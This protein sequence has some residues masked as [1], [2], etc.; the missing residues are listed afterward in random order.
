MEGEGEKRLTT[1]CEDLDFVVWR[2]KKVFFCFFS[3]V[4][5]II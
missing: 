2:K 5:F 1:N 3:L 4:F